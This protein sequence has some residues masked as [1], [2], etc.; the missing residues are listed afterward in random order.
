MY[1]QTIRE[2]MARLGRVGAADPRHIEAWMR[3]EH[4][5]LDALSPAQFSAEVSEA[6]NCIAASTPAEN[7]SLADSFG[8]GA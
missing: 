8:F 1:Q 3:L 4:S 5:T 6:L 7:Q 2:T